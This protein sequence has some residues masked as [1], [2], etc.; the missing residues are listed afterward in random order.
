MSLAYPLNPLF[1][2]TR[3]RVTCLSIDLRLDESGDECLGV[4]MSERRLPPQYLSDLHTERDFDS[5]DSVEDQH[6][7][8]AIEIDE[9]GGVDNG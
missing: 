8:L 7:Q 6:A 2:L 4:E 5:L 1:V 3:R 9:S